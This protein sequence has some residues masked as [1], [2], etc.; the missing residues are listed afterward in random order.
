MFRIGGNHELW[1]YHSFTRGPLSLAPEAESSLL[2]GGVETLEAA[3]YWYDGDGRGLCTPEPRSGERGNM[4]KSEVNG[5]VT[6]YVGKHYEKQVDGVTEKEIKYYTANRQTL[7][8]RENGT[9][10]WLLS[11]HLGSTSVT[12]DA[13]GNLVS[14]LRYTAFGEVRLPVI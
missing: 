5:V 14:S 6:Y 9:L 7:A 12:A 11:D 8:M 4:V 3:Y 10:T 2:S 1:T 13:S